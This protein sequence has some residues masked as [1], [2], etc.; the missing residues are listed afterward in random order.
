[1]LIYQ[2]FSSYSMLWTILIGLLTG[3]YVP[4]SN[5]IVCTVIYDKQAHTQ[6]QTSAV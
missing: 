4:A 3:A 5:Q 1:M 6:E 2:K